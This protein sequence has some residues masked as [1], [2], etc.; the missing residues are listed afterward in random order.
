[1][2]TQCFGRLDS[3]AHLG[4]IKKMNC[5]SGTAASVFKVLYYIFLSLKK[6]IKSAFPVQTIVISNGH[7]VPLGRCGPLQVITGCLIILASIFCFNV[8][9]LHIF[10][11]VFEPQK[12]KFYTLVMKQN[13][14]NVQMLSY[15]VFWPD[16]NNIQ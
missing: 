6:A 7:A 12:C 9:Y 13:L 14:L 15:Q 11:L 8:R 4:Q 10:L 16:F 1:M 3:E 2:W 5:F